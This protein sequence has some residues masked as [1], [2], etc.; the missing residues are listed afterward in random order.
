M[1]RAVIYI[2]ISTK[3][4]AARDGNP[5]GYSLPTQREACHKKAEQLGAAV[6]EEYVNT[7]TAPPSASVRPCSS[8]S[9]VSGP[10]ATLT[11]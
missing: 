4:Q 9:S 2:R 11:T 7:D 3:Q 8:S 6:V 5:E 10:P 1:K